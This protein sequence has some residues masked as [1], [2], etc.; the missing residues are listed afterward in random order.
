MRISDWSSDVCSSDLGSDLGQLDAL[1]AAG[2]NNGA[3][4][5]GRSWRPETT[6]I[7]AGQVGGMR[8]R[9]ESQAFVSLEDGRGRIQCAFFAEAYFESAQLLT[10]DRILI[11]EGGLRSEARRVGKEGVSK[12]RSRGTL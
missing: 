9:G 8:K 3:P 10:S 5:E 4:K 2:Q 12:C 6:V 11:D 7:I 1:W